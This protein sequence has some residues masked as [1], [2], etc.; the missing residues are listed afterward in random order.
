MLRA[1]AILLLVCGLHLL[2][3]PQLANL[4]TGNPCKVILH[5]WRDYGYWHLDGQLVMNPGGID[6]G[7]PLKIYYGHRPAVLILPYLLEELP[8]AAGG[9]GL[10]YDLIV[11]ALTYS[12]LVWLF[13]TGLRGL[14]LASVACLTPGVIY[15]ILQID[16]IGVPALFGIPVM[17]FAARA[18]TRPE[19]SASLRVT[20]FLVVAVYMLMNWPTVFPLGIMI[21]YVLVPK[22]RLEKNRALFLPSTPYR[23]R[24]RRRVPGRPPRQRNQ[25]SRFLERLLLGSARL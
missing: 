10:L 17:C 1:A 13:G 16:T 22:L 14:L 23:N 6:P 2:I 7:E 19:T 9:N 3:Y 15:S 20:A 8:G 21:V 4:H 18:F 5:N 12:A 24:R 25:R 11:V